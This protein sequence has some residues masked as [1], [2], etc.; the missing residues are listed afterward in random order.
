MLPRVARWTVLALAT[1]ALGVGLTALGVPSAALFAALVVAVGL[2]LAGRAPADVPRWSALAAQAV[3]GVLIGVLVQRETLV[4]LGRD[5]LPVVGISVA[6]LALSVLAG[7][8]LGLHRDVDVLT[9]S[10]ALTA[11]GA[12]GLTAIS[13]ELGADE[14]VVAVVQYLRVAL[15]VALMPMV[16]ALAFD[17]GTPSAEPGGAAAPW[18][19]DVGFVLAC[20]VGGTVLARLVRLPVAA[21][22]GPMVAAGALSLTGVAAGAEVP[23]AAV[24]LAYVVIGW[25]AGL[26]FTRASLRTVGRVLPAA[27]ALIG[28][29]VAGC[30]GLG[31]ALAAL[32]GASPLDAYLATTPGGVYA[33]LATSASYGG[34]VTFVVAVQVLR[35]VI[36]VL[37]APLLA[38]ALSRWLGRGGRAG[39]PGR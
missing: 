3:L 36:M 22:L 20:G 21:L 30:A 5:W 13:R 14:R 8:A 4:S 7:L 12:S 39:Y 11:G 26:G 27:L 35:V 23:A 9:G 38:R 28:L 16:A 32:T 17:P 31:V 37:A 19:F 34:D 29:V 1:A 33:V 18:W 24:V 10:L 25:Q 2:A 15:V 6:T